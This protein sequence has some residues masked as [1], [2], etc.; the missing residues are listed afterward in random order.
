MESDRTFFEFA[1]ALIPA[2]LFG[3]LISERV[4][5]PERLGRQY[6]VGFIALISGGLFV[7]IAEIL[8]IHTAITGTPDAVDRVVVSAAVIGLSA[9]AF[10]LMG[11]PW[12]EKLPRPER[13]KWKV[14]FGGS[15]LVIAVMSVL[16]FDSAISLSTAEDTREKLEATFREQTT[17][18]TR[19]QRTLDQLLAKRLE[20]SRVRRQIAAVGKPRSSVERLRLRTLKEDLEVLRTQIKVLTHRAVSLG[21]QQLR[22]YDEQDRLL[23]D[24]E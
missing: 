11:L 19:D 3:G 5:P 12:V 9:G 7:L 2:L 18:L 24:L 16:L 13:T 20:I 14:A 6:T 10:A 22:L 15:L 4:R 8:A 1:A 23:N 21:R 17:L